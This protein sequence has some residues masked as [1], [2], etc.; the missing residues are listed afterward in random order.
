[1][2]PVVFGCAG[3][4]LSDEE[5]AFFSEVKPA[6]FILF[7][8]N[9]GTPDEVRALVTALKKTTGRKHVP[10]MIDQEGG[11]VQR[12]KAPHWR[13]YPPMETFGHMARQDATLGASALRL[14]CR[15]IADDL[16]QLGIN[17]NCLPVLDVP[18]R[19]ADKVIG[20]RAFAHD[21]QLVGALGRIALES[22]ADGGVLGV[23]K[24][25][26][27][28]G[29]SL[30]D[31]HHGLP[32]VSASLEDLSKT[33]FVPFAALHDAPFAMTAHIIYQAI[34]PAR[35]ATLSKVVI[36]RIIRMKIGFQGI[37]FSDDLSM[38]A[39]DGAIEKR[40]ADA[41]AAGC[42]IALHCNG[43]LAEMKAIAA[44]VPRASLKLEERLAT[45]IEEVNARQGVDRADL[46]KRYRDLMA[47]YKPE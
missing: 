38:N 41:L 43:N 6:G 26:P 22:L 15:L 3:T 12:L 40:A 7:A 46:E 17:V 24:H 4:T 30:V 13:A 8:R 33:D 21:P 36:G 47:R 1:M 9:V 25:I 35:P 23:L 18:Q 14:N 16:V 5:A 20:D 2:I 34:D 11:R 45:L 28:H 19:G 31:S 42:D 29:R 10:V 27:G 44:A 32:R 37:L 39:L